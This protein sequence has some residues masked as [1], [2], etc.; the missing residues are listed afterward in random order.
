M[1]CNLFAMK[2]EFTKH[3]LSNTTFLNDRRKKI[4][5]NMTKKEK[6]EGEILHRKKN[7]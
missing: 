7:E 1:I 2:D 4:I 3:S 5:N 6:K